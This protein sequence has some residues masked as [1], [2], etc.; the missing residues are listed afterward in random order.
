MEKEFL[1]K[2]LEYWNGVHKPI[3]RDAI[4]TDDWLELF[5]DIIEGCKTPVLDLGCGTGNDTLYLIEKGKQVISCDLSENAIANIKKNFPEVLE[6]KCFNMLE[7]LPFEDHAYELVIADLCLHYFSETDT[8]AVIAEIK[9]VLKPGG[10]L[11][12][13]VNSVND[14]NHGAGCG[15][16]LEPHLYVS[17]AGTTKRF[18]NEEDIRYFFKDFEI[19]YLKEEIMSRYK[20]EKR[21]Y[22]VCLRAR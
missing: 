4:P 18:F 22:R 13:R 2:A 19:E 8:H 16:E 14:V 11:I 3:E 7:G 20:L 9:R 17:S 15:R 1:E 10:H 5:D 21:L 12:L 6:A